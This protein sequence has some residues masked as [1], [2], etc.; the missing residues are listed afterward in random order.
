MFMA[1]MT[2]P[3]TYY[4]IIE[5]LGAGM[6]EWTRRS[7]VAVKAGCWACGVHYTILCPL[8]HART[9]SVPSYTFQNFRKKFYQK[10]VYPNQYSTHAGK[11]AKTGKTVRN[12]T[13]F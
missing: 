13:K 9:F 8:T 11:R 2:I 10:K 3:G 6:T 12:S 5:C 1:E 7:C 4:K